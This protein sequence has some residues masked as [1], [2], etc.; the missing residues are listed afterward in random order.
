[1]GVYK[2]AFPFILEPD[3][4]TGASKLQPITGVENFPW[5]LTLSL[6]AQSQFCVIKTHQSFQSHNDF[7]WQPMRSWQR[8]VS[9]VR[10]FEKL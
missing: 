1:M 9:S 10:S 4:E 6:V 2:V 8:A 3:I 5:F 7:E